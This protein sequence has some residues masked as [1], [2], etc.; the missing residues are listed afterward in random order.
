M[1][2]IWYIVCSNSVLL[3]VASLHILVY[4][5]PRILR[6]LTMGQASRFSVE[7]LRKQCFGW[8]ERHSSF[9]LRRDRKGSNYWTMISPIRKQSMQLIIVVN[10]VKD[11]SNTSQ[12][13]LTQKC[14]VPQSSMSPQ[15]LEPLWTI[16]F[17]IHKQSVQHKRSSVF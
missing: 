1:R 16:C 14:C 5:K 15:N 3:H 7:L 17:Q 10:N 4:R 9:L 12:H 11:Y 6:G 8:K 2:G 13:F